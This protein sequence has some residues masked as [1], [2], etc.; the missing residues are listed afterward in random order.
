MNM[1][2]A[3]ELEQNIRAQI[4]SGDIKISGLQNI[5]PENQKKIYESY[6][7][8]LPEIETRL[9]NV[10]LST[11]KNAGGIIS[12]DGKGLHFPETSKLEVAQK[13]W[14]AFLDIRPL[15][16]KTI[17]LFSINGKT[18]RARMVLNKINIIW[19]PDIKEDEKQQSEDVL[20][21]FSL[22]PSDF[23]KTGGAI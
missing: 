2:V 16:V 15:I 14:L 9:I 20:K 8:I 13:A 19:P 4:E 17:N 23:D 22:C 5:P 18:I 12:P 1:S 11:I 3:I 7:R 10:A 21:S 6:I